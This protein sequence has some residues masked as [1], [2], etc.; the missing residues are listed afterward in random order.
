M[1]ARLFS[2]LFSLHNAMILRVCIVSYTTLHVSVSKCSVQFM[3]LVV[4]CLLVLRLAQFCSASSLELFFFGN[5][6]T[7]S[8]FFLENSLTNT[9]FLD[10]VELF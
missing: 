6:L 5:N 7:S 1:C 2:W 4:G 8:S 10:E 9:S 3:S